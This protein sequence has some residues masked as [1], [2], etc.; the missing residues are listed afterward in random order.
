M[1]TAA[2]F[3]QSQYQAAVARN[4]AKIATEQAGQ[5]EI[6]GRQQQDQVNRHIAATEASE[7]AGFGAAGVVLGPGT[8]TDVLRDTAQKGQIDI[9]TIQQNTALKKWGFMVDRSNFL[10]QAKADESSAFNSL[11]AGGIGATGSLLKSAGQTNLFGS[12]GGSGGSG[13]GGSSTPPWVYGAS[14]AG[15]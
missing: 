8:T 3:E 13:S 15:D 10:A 5:A 9:N 1:S 12:W 11:L 6:Q 14:I 4:N 7:R 2:K